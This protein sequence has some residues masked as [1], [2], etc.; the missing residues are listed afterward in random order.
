MV[1]D[2]LGGKTIHISALLWK[3][4]FKV[5][6]SIGILLEIGLAGLMFANGGVD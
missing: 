3:S 1:S 5:I 2:S 6:G 4:S